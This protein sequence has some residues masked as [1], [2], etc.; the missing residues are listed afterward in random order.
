MSFTKSTIHDKTTIFI[1]TT[2]STI[3]T[4]TAN[5][6]FLTSD[7]GNKNKIIIII[8]R[9]LDRTTN[10]LDIVTTTI[11]STSTPTTFSI[12]TSLTPSITTPNTTTPLSSPVTISIASSSSSPIDKG[13]SSSFP[14]HVATI[15]TSS[16]SPFLYLISLIIIP[17]TILIIILVYSFKRRYKII[18]YEPVQITN[19]K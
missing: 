13:N 3:F 6:S 4:I 8:Y 5:T 14:H 9:F 11:T 10:I 18:V 19:L 1:T 7:K 15:T 12:V 17:F 16:Q 2:T